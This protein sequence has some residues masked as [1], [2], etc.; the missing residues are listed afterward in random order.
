MSLE[1]SQDLLATEGE[2]SFHAKVGKAIMEQIVAQ[3]NELPK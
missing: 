3:L 2:A 1:L